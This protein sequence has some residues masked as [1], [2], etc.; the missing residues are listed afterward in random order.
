VN[1]INREARAEI[2][3]GS[4][5]EPSSLTLPSGNLVIDVFMD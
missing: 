3:K 4:E 1:N 5:T 2:I